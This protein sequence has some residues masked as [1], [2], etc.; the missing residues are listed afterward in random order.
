MAWQTPVLIAVSITILALPLLAQGAAD[1][2]PGLAAKYPGD[3]GIDNDPAVVFA[4]DFEEDSL[5]EATKHWTAASKTMS[6]V[7]EGPEGSPGTRAMRMTA[8]RG[9]STG[10]SLYRTFP[11]GYDRLYA[12]FYV[13]FAP[14]SPYIH[15][16]VHLGGL[17]DLKP[18]PVTRA[19]VR[20][21]G[22]YGFSVSI[23]PTGLRGRCPPPGAWRPYVYWCEMRQS[24]DGGYWGNGLHPVQPTFAPRGEWTCIEC[25]IKCNTPPDTRD[26]ELAMWVD[27]KEAIRIVA[28][29]RRGPW[30]GQGF[31]LVEEGGEPFEGFLWRTTDCLKVNYFRLLHYVTDRVFADTERLK[32]GF[33]DL[34]I[35]TEKAVVWFD[36]VVLATEYVGPLVPADE[37]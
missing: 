35:N 14:D 12:R 34:D 19:G 23:E 5:E 36:H 33:P 6:L 27:G 22:D 1:Q 7:E 10:G 9:E 31:H 20:P 25:M 8:S 15:H 16:F 2:R 26:G 3:V 24:S 4:E 30:S 32:D 11:P 21:A 13:K 37:R 29:V 28:G 17:A 18:W